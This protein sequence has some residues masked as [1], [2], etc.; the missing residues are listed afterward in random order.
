[1]GI[2]VKSRHRIAT[3]DS[4]FCCFWNF[5]IL[6]DIHL[7]RYAICIEAS[8]FQVRDKSIQFFFTDFRDMQIPKKGTRCVV[9]LVVTIVVVC[10]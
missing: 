6:Y 7:T 1:M 5:W 2:M 4:L 9:L 10:A 8:H 3:T